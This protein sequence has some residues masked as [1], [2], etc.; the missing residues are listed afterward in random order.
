MRICHDR[1]TP[2]LSSPGKDCKNR[3]AFSFSSLEMRGSSFFFLRDLAVEAD[4]RDCGVMD[5]SGDG[6]SGALHPL[7]RFATMIAVR[8]FRHGGG[9]FIV[10]DGIVEWN[11]ESRLPH[12]EDKPAPWR[13]KVSEH[14]TVGNV[15]HTARHS[16]ACNRAFQSI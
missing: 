15:F 9:A 5:Q 6:D 16:P 2:S 13:T 14:Y 11:R 10:S 12:R 1:P 8:R 3:R 7:E 4:A